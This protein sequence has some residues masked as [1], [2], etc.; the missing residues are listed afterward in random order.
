MDLHQK[1]HDNTK[2]FTLIELIAVMAL[3]TVLMSF[4]VP[5]FQESLLTDDLKKSVMDLTGFINSV[6]ERA[7][8]E[9]KPYFIAF[10]LGSNKYWAI[11]GDSSEEERAL[12]GE[13]AMVLPGDVTIRVIEI[14]G[15]GK[16]DS[17]TAEVRFNKKGYTLRSVIILQDQDDREMSLLIRSYLRRIEIIDQGINLEEL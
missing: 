17:G 7:I 8:N 2:G 5:K 16:F 9:Q 15:R 12:A 10:D 11:P 13:D 6:R 14:K 1:M 3:L 4:V